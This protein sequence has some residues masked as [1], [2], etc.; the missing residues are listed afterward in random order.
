MTA[1]LNTQDVDQ[2]N[3]RNKRRTA[4][5]EEKASKHKKLAKGDQQEQVQEKKAAPETM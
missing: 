2:A 4:A 3:T 1:V 5:V